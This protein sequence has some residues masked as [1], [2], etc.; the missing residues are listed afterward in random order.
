MAKSVGVGGAARGG[1]LAALLAEKGLTGPERPIEGPRGFTAV[2][3]DR[4]NLSTMIDGLGERWEILANTYKPYPCGVVLNP[5]ID[6]CL[7]LRHR[8]GVRPEQVRRVVVRG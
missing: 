2:M 3:G 8:H 4:A 1:L 7:E 6:A 5:V